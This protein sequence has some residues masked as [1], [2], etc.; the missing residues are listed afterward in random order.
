[1]STPGEKLSS[2]QKLKRNLQQ[3]TGPLK[4]KVTMES[5][6]KIAKRKFRR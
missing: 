5:T 6:K 4:S 1:M 3:G 2:S